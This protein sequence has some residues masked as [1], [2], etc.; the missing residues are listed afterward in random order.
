LPGWGDKVGGMNK[1]IE[2]LSQIC[3]KHRFDEKLLFV[4]SYSIGHQ[5]GEYL[6]KTGRSWI[7]LRVTTNN[8]APSL[9]AYTILFAFKA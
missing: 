5:I 9:I 8:S 3:E 2:I 1:T 6:A 7:N 4:P